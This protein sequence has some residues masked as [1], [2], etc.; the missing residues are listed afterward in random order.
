MRI[1]N[2]YNLPESIVRAVT[3]DDYDRVGFDLSVTELIN[4]PYMARLKREHDHEI[5]ED[6][7]ARL[8]ALQGGS[9]HVVLER[10]VGPGDTAE[11]RV[12]L[13]LDNGV[14]VAGRFDLLKADGTLYDFKLTSVYSIRSAQRQEKAEWTNQLNLLAYL[15]RH[16]AT[17]SPS[18]QASAES[19]YWPRIEKLAIMAIARDWRP[20]EAA[21][22]FDYPPRACAVPVPLWPDAQAR[23][24]LEERVRLHTI[25]APP[26]CTPEERWFSGDRIALMQKGRARALRLF[27]EQPERVVLGAGQY[28]EKRPGAYR[29]CE[30]YCPVSQFCPVWGEVRAAQIKDEAVAVGAE[31]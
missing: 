2:N 10:A 17:R 12:Y 26:P 20:G 29:R 23:A 5:E 31:E 18:G 14:T 16:G 28:W 21:R 9:M 1:T 13:T 27:D 19:A 30:Q 8:W 6:A 25:D 22:D 11:R 15:I 7:T 4:P 24:Y 3:F